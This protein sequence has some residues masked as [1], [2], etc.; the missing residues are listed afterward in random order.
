M[1]V[2]ISRPLAD[3][4]CKLGGSPPF[5]F[6]SEKQV[7][8]VTSLHFYLF[9]QE[10]KR[11]GRGVKASNLPLQGSYFFHQIPSSHF[12]PYFFFISFLFHSTLPLTLTKCRHFNSVCNFLPVDY[13]S[14]PP[15]PKK[16]K[17]KKKNALFIPY[18]R[19]R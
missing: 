17:Q 6:L 18:F 14:E 11:G 5:L 15:Y 2:F 1:L 12:N 19:N 9:P 16:Q 10:R 4:S 13:V 7:T 3:Y 8:S